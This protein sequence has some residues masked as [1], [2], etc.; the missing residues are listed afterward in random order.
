MASPLPGVGDPIRV[1]L[2]SLRRLVVF[3]ALARVSDV[4][5]TVSRAMLERKFGGPAWVEPLMKA[6][7]ELQKY[8]EKLRQLQGGSLD[9]YYLFLVL[10]ACHAEF[11]EHERAEQ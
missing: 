11:F 5:S 1:S 6:K 9:L 7:P 4:L 10:Q 2:E 8:V 3:K